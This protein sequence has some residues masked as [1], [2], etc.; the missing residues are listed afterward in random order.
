MAAVVPR[1][2]RRRST[3]ARW[4]SALDTMFRLA[5]AHP[6]QWRGI[7]DVLTYDQLVLVSETFS[8]LDAHRLG[9]IPATV[10]S[11]IGVIWHVAPKCMPTTAADKEHM[12]DHPRGTI[13]IAMDTV[14]P[15]SSGPDSEFLLDL[16][17]LFKFVRNFLE[18]EWKR[19][20]KTMFSKKQA[21]RVTRA[22]L[23]FDQQRVDGSR[24]GLRTQQVFDL[25]QHLGYGRDLLTSQGQR[26]LIERTS[27]VDYNNDGL[28]NQNEFWQL[29]WIYHREQV[30][31]ERSRE[32]GLIRAT[33]YSRKEVHDLRQVFNLLDAENERGS[34][35]M[36]QVLGLFK[37]LC[38]EMDADQKA[39]LKDL[40]RNAFAYVD[41]DGSNTLDFGEFVSLMATI[42]KSN[43]AGI[44]DT[45]LGL[46]T[47]SEDDELE[48]LGQVIAGDHE[49]AGEH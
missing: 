16:L 46:I 5:D 38:V 31:M 44:H 40:V 37:A 13:G 15:A 2:Q 33:G 17:G 7:E 24:S 22:Y 47:S 34:L 3:V 42:L 35:E 39:E 8:R 1:S 45:C 29:I 18:A 11:L 10:D 4:S 28:L 9:A 27:S 21:D 12:V 6:I 23:K 25:W 41:T 19:T 32:L 43:F 30:Q 26:L 48:R 20:P 36:A 49:E 14:R